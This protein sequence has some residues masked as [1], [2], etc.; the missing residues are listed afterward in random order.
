MCTGYQTRSSPN[1]TRTHTRFLQQNKAMAFEK[2]KQRGIELLIKQIP[3]LM[4]KSW[5][6]TLIGIAGAIAIVST[7]LVNLFDN[8]PNTIFSLE[9][10]FAALA[11]FGIGA[12]ARDNGVT[13]E[14][15]G[16][17]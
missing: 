2:I 7:Q 3:K 9:A 13:S 6:T 5:K 4:N 10:I 12:A 14:K 8:D 17:K 1:T 15:A 16:V 11:V